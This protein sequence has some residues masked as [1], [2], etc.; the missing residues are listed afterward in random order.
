MRQIESYSHQVDIS[1]D[2]FLKKNDTNAGTQK[3]KAKLDEFAFFEENWQKLEL[4]TTF[5]LK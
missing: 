3:L 4:K 5:E 2:F 1:K